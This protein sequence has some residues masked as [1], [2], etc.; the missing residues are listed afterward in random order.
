MEEFII[1]NFFRGIMRGDLRGYLE[2]RK[3]TETYDNG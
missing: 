3:T 2:R 1:F